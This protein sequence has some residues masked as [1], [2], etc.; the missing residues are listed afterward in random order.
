MAICICLGC[1]LVMMKRV[2]Q[3]YLAVEIEAV[4]SYPFIFP[5]RGAP[6]GGIPSAFG[7]M[8]KP[9]AQCCSV[10]QLGFRND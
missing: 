5:Q 8:V 3:Q 10:C 2:S 7:S 9:Y 1:C 4:S 6:G